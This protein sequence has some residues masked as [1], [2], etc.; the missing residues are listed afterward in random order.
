MLRKVVWLAWLGVTMAALVAAEWDFPPPERLPSR[1]GLPDPLVMWDGSK[2][3]TPQDWFQKRVPELRALFQHYM[4]GRIPAPLPVHAKELY[5][6][7]QAFDG[8]GTL[9]E[10][11]LHIGEKEVN[12]TVHVL[13][14]IP[15]QRNGKVPAFVGMNFGGNHTLVDDPN[16]QLPTV[17]M[18]PNRPGV[19]NNRATEAG[20][21]RDKNVWNL[22]LAISRGYAVA[23]FYNGEIQPDH[24]EAQA[25]LLPQLFRDRPRRPTDTATIAA[26]AWGIHRV[27]DYLVTVPELDAKRIA[28]VGHSRLGKTALLAGAFDERLALIIPHQ[29]GCGGTAPSRGKI[30]ESV[31][32]INDR[33]PYWF[34]GQFKQFNRAVEKL[35]FDQHCLI[36]LCA[37]RPVLLTNAVKTPGQIPLANSTCLWP[38]T[39]FIAFLVLKA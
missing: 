30:G 12:L 17:W 16:V 39:Q 6:N 11:A 26:W 18:Y 31:Q 25:G 29:A 2:V 35:P 23:T 14:A 37:P 19:V 22:D 32:A 36:A 28:V 27:V 8:R 9:R 33:F 24:P 20:R 3:A 21:G 13:L 34:N 1:P 5:R 4:Y 38:P 7:T 10:V 15:N